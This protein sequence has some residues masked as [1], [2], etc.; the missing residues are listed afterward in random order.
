M[1]SDDKEYLKIMY[2]ILFWICWNLESAAEVY[3]GR[4]KNVAPGS[5]LERG[6]LDGEAAFM[7]KEEVGGGDGGWEEEGWCV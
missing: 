1:L 3:L 6:L 2:I 7:S 4:N 5:W